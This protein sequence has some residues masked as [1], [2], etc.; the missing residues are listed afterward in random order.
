MKKFTM[1]MVVSMMFACGG[2][3]DKKNNKTTGSNNSTGTNNSS[4][5][6]K[7]N[8]TGATNNSTGTNNNSTGASNNSTGTTGGTTNSDLCFEKTCENPIPACEGTTA[9]T[10]TDAAT[11]NPDNGECVNGT[12]ARVDCATTNQ[13]CELGVCVDTCD[14][15]TV[16]DAPADTCAGSVL[17][18]YSG[19]GMCDLAAGA[20]SYTAVTVTTDCDTNQEVCQVDKC[21]DLC[22]TKMCIPPAGFCTGDTATSYSGNGMCAYLDGTCDYT[23]VETVTDCTLGGQTCLGGACI[24]GTPVAPVAGDLVVTEILPNPNGSD[25]NTEWFEI[26]N[27]SLT[28]ILLNGLVLSDLGNNS[29]TITAVADLVVNPGQY[30]VLGRNAE[31]GA[32][33]GVAVDYAYGSAYSLSNSGTAI[34]DEV[35]IKDANDVLIDEVYYSNAMGVASGFAIQV[36]N[37]HNLS[38]VDNNDAQ[39]W[40]PATTLFNGVDYGTPGTAN[41]NCLP[42][43]P[44]VVVSIYE[45]QDDTQANHPTVNAAVDVKGVVVTANTA[46][47]IWVQEVAGGEYSGINLRD[48]GVAAALT[49]TVGDTIDFVGTYIERFGNST[50]ALSSVTVNASGA[51]TTAELIDSAI[52]ADPIEAEKWEGVLVQINE[53]GVTQENADVLPANNNETL[54]DGV[55]R[56]D[57]AL[58]NFTQP[59]ACT[60]FD[61]IVG[62][63]DYS[64]SNYKIQPRN[65]A[66]MVVS[67]TPVMN[68]VGD[69]TAAISIIGTGGGFSPKV[70]CVN[71]TTDVTITNDDAAVSHDAVS[72]NPAEVAPNNFS[73]VNSLV[74]AI[75]APGSQYTF[76]ANPE[77]TE[78]Y[79]CT[80]HAGMEGVI[81]VV[82][83]P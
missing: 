67:T 65:A 79:R 40:C 34:I 38:S 39:F 28:P 5:S 8:S 61:S 56:I 45:I 75:L 29:H 46:G 73:P 48:N 52:F 43:A 53:A 55:I 1:L 11:C 49:L 83:A 62:P 23:G 6:T 76:Q 32:N 27:V 30:Y 31:M 68:A 42:P 44:P 60:F 82:P 14:A 24:G 2:D 18:S 64:F 35:I 12:E 4:T 22:A 77:G 19:A 9:V 78:H 74:P 10:F 59:A 13:A 50:V 80:P 17:T 7:N 3:D 15:N 36:G 16:C 70:L 20:C 57:D 26:K 25:T 37:Q 66:D 47:N 51:A 81:I 21:V 33:G 63:V 69:L 41:D 71:A 58:T 72:R 54:L